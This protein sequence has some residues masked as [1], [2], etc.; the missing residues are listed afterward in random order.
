M[1]FW[2][3]CGQKKSYKF[4]R[5]RYSSSADF[6]TSEACYSAVIENRE[7]VSI[8]SYI[9]VPSKTKRVENF[10]RI[11]RSLFFSGPTR[12]HDLPYVRIETFFVQ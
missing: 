10:L 1:L 4:Y 8:L 5:E 6:S 3:V 2:L 7:N 11:S 12:T 9:R